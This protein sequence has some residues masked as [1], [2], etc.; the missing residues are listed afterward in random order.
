MKMHQLL[1]LRSWNFRS[2]EIE[3]S[4]TCSIAKLFLGVAWEVASLQLRLLT[5]LY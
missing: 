5:V 1:V 2:W 3:F 4:S